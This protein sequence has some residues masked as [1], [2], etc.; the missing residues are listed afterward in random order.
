MT[1]SRLGS[2]DRALVHRTTAGDRTVGLVGSPS[3]ALHAIAELLRI[4]ESSVIQEDSS[5]SIRPTLRVEE[6][7]LESMRDL[8]D[9]G[10]TAHA[11]AGLVQGR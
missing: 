3:V 4:L 7:Q 11:V 5:A 8:G 1:G 9:R 2:S 6:P 10:L